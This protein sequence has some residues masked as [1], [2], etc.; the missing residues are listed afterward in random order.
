[1][2]LYK[3]WNKPL[4]IGL[5]YLLNIVVFSAV[6]WLCF[7]SAFKVDFTLNFIQALYFSIVTVTTLGFGDITPNL[8]SSSLLIC[9]VV[10][11]ILGVLN[12]G[13]FLNSIFNK[14]SLN[15]EKEIKEQTERLN[16]EQIAKVL[17]ILKPVVISQLVI[18][19]DIYKSTYTSKDISKAEFKITPK[20]LMNDAY[21][22][23]VCLIDYY[24]NYDTKRM[25][26][27]VLIEKNNQFQS[28]L[29][30]FLSKFAYSL[31]IDML[32]LINDIQCHQ[33][34]NY[35]K[36]A[37]L[38]YNVDNGHVEPRHM[39][40]LEHSARIS[41]NKGA[42]LHMRDYHLKLLSLI[43]VIDEH[44]PK[45]KVVMR[46]S[47]V[48]YILPPV[49]SSIAKMFVWG[50]EEQVEIDNLLCSENG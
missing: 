27:D 40:S 18:L 47:L 46:I 1:M 43:E 2:T 24:S 26:A 6:Y 13:L 11:V 3:T 33:Y 38:S 36:I 19:S 8:D 48:E 42:P 4:A 34:F 35:P 17:T 29:D 5:L 44:L 39:V 16:K 7:A 25:F 50:G 23:Q 45:E 28:G 41:S 10:Q 31:D 21:Y 37:K 22:D 12:I 14:I 32:T 30:S 20:K 9:I 49:G 15:K